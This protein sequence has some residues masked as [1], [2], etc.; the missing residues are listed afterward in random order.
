MPFAKGELT[1]LFEQL[2][3]QLALFLLKTR[4]S[5]RHWQFCD[6]IVSSVRKGNHDFSITGSHLT[7]MPCSAHYTDEF[8]DLLEEVSS[9]FLMNKFHFPICIHSIGENS[10]FDFSTRFHFGCELD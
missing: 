10:P 9:P 5:V 7:E 3:E 8:S 4:S 2:R 1:T 6:L